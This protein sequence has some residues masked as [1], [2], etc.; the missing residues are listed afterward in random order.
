MKHMPRTA[1]V[2][3]MTPKQTWRHA[4]TFAL[5]PDQCVAKCPLKSKVNTRAVLINFQAQSNQI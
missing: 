1:E 5:K 2:Y 3:V 4:Q